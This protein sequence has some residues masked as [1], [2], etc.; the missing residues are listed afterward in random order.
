MSSGEIGGQHY[1]VTEATDGGTVND[2]L[3][4]VGPLPELKAI[5][6]VRDCAYA[7]Q[8]AWD[9]ARLTHGDIDVG[10]IRLVVERRGETRRAGACAARRG[11]A[12]RRYAS[13]G[14]ALYQMLVNEPRLQPHQS[15]PDLS[16]KRSG[17]GPFVGEVVEKMLA[18]AVWNY[19]SYGPA[20]RRPRRSAGPAPAA[21]HASEAFTRS[22]LRS[23]CDCRRRTDNTGTRATAAARDVQMEFTTRPAGRVADPRRCCWQMWEY[24]DRTRLL[25]LPPAP[26]TPPPPIALVPAEPSPVVALP[27][28][29]DIADAAERGRA[30]AKYLGVNRLQAGFGG[31]VSV[32]DDGQMR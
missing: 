28:F 11:L 20:Y 8:A 2:L 25:P 32:V 26:S 4:S 15:T 27:T 30:M 17:I 12:R 6:I 7:L 14:D 29:E 31:M 24:S 1:L 21:A 22:R 19:A 18:K 10:K 9:A 23:G 5:Q 16:S 13:T 3:L